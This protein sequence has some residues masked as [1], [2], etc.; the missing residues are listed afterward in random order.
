MFIQICFCMLVLAAQVA[1]WIPSL[2]ITAGSMAVLFIAG[3][4]GSDYVFKWSAKA[5]QQHR[6]KP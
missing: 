5:I 3:A 1:T 2:A 4:S 6:D